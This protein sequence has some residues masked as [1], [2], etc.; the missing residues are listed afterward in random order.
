MWEEAENGE[1]HLPNGN[2]VS[3][4][5]GHDPPPTPGSSWLREF[6]LKTLGLIKGRVGG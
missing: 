1:R 3:V 4:C 5:C 2:A 6:L